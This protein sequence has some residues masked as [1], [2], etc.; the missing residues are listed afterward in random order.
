MKK[1]SIAFTTIIFMALVSTVVFHYLR[2]GEC[3]DNSCKNVTVDRFDTSFGGLKIDTSGDERK[4]SCA[5]TDDKYLVLVEGKRNYDVVATLLLTAHESRHR[6]EI[7]VYQS[8][9]CVIYQ[10]ISDS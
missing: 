9:P 2:F 5:P 4:L 6:I 8:S 1:L 7:K 10:V 3:A